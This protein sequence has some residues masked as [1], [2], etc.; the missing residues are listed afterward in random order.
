LG[1]GGL[2]LGLGLVLVLSAWAPGAGAKTSA[3]L[4]INGA[5]D[6]S[7]KSL[8]AGVNDAQAA[9]TLWI[10][11]TCT[12]T[13]EIAKDLTLTGQQ[14]RGFTAPT[15]DGGSQGSVL[16]IDTGVAVTINTLT[17]TGGSGTNLEGANV[18][19]GIFNSGGA[20]VL[21]DTNITGNNGGHGGGIA[22][23]QGSVTL[24]DSSISGNTAG[25]ENGGVFNVDGSVTLNGSSSISDN[26][27]GGGV[28]GDGGGIGSNGGTVTLNDSSS[29][30]GNTAVTEGG[31]VSV[32]AAASVTLNDSSSISGNT[33][34]TLGGGIY[35]VGNSSVTLNDSSSITGNTAGAD[36]GGI[37]NDVFAGPVT[38]NDSSSITGNTPNNCAPPGSVVGCTG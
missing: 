5:A 31:G 37:Y 16:T 30:S 28:P 18:G 13:T 11:G 10:R 19:G 25:L 4:V 26:T 6:T 8:Q 35:N 23:G 24:N 29:I 20:V 7:Y 21:N 34:G 33:A 15:L 14:P 12:G 27:V 22:S 17:I 9:A 36:G 3:C 1:R 38:L 2:V 32:I